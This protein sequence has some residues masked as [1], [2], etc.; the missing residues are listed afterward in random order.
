[1]V[2][3]SRG[4]MTRFAKCCLPIPGDDI[5]GFVSQGRGVTVHRKDCVNVKTLDSNRFI[6]VAWDE[7]KHSNYLARIIVKTESNVIANI[8]NVLEKMGVKISAL[9]INPQDLNEYMITISLKSNDELNKVISK[10]RQVNDVINV[11]RV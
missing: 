10:V 2:D 9:E 6:P 5:I 8:S 7:D 11:N 3:N 4:M 1:M